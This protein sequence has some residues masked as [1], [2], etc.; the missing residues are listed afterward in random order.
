MTPPRLVVAAVAIAAGSIAVGAVSGGVPPVEQCAG[1]GQCQEAEHLNVYRLKYR[2][3]SQEFVAQDTARDCFKKGDYDFD[4]TPGLTAQDNFAPLVMK[5]GQ[6]GTFSTNFL[7]VAGNEE[8]GR[9][10]LDFLGC[11][12]DADSQ[13]VCPNLRA[14]L[15]GN[16]LDFKC[17]RMRPGGFAIQTQNNPGMCLP[18]IPDDATCPDTVSWNQGTDT[19][20]QVEI[21]LECCPDCCQSID[22]VPVDNDRRR[23]SLLQEETTSPGSD[24]IQFNCWTPE[25]PPTEIIIQGMIP[26]PITGFG[27]MTPPPIKLPPYSVLSLSVI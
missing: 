5:G 23:R 6:Q 19:I 14:E 13:V 27:L 21:L 25:P 9:V 11:R 8:T 22:G 2:P 24:P 1:L 16:L 12:M 18:G 20:V 26:P 15:T 10:E 17:Q 3:F 7:G 4:I